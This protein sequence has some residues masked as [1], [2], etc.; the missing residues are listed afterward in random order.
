[1]STKDSLGIIID[2]VNEAGLI[3]RGSFTTTVPTTANKFAAG[4]ILIGNDGKVYTNAGTSASPS[5]QD[6]NDVTTSEIADGA[7]TRAK[8]ESAMQTS[9]PYTIKKSVTSPQLLALNTTPIE[10]IAAPGAGKAIQVLG[11]FIA[12]TYATAAYATNTTLL[13]VNSTGTNEIASDG[14]SLISD[15]SSNKGYM[16]IA[17]GINSI[18]TND[19]VVIEAQTGDPTDGGGTIDVYVTYQI[20]TL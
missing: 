18:V 11:A 14:G 4:C 16:T 7:V 12:Y 3:T 9:V 19:S 17:G 1:M 8:L 5:F 10:V 2:N 20:I 15:T 6:I 13:L